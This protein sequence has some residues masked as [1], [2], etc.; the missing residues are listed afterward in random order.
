MGEHLPDQ[1]GPEIVYNSSITTVIIH[2]SFLL[3]IVVK[4]TTESLTTP[5]II[6][7]IHFHGRI[8]PA[9]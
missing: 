3:S 5:D 6:G 7:H 2:D 8:S 9:M 1:Q 4:G